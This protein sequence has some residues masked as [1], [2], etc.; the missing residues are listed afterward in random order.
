M[1]ASL[2]EPDFQMC[3]PPAAQD[4]GGTPQAACSGSLGSGVVQNKQHRTKFQIGQGRSK[5]VANTAPIE[6]G[7]LTAVLAFGT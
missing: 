1:I 5:A 7:F 6:K 4:R 3:V 2:E